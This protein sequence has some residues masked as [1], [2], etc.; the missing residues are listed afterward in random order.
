MTVESELIWL[1]ILV[2]IWREIEVIERTKAT[3]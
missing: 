3:R 1:R 2:N